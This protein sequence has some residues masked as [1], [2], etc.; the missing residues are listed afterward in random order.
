RLR[1]SFVNLEDS[2]NDIYINERYTVAASYRLLLPELLPELEKVIYID[3]D[4]LVRNNLAKVYSEIELGNNYLAGVFEA[5]LDFQLPHMEAIG[6]K[7]GSY[8]NSGFLVMN[9][10][11]LRRDNM[12]SK[13][14]EASKEHCWEFPDQDVLNKL[15]RERVLGLSPYYNS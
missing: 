5:T 12:T 8:I 9:L 15:C 6:C 10:E 2:L 11:L 7:P 4:V 3:C 13:F 1:F 14:I